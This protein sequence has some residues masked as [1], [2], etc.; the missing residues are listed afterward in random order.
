MRAQQNPLP[1]NPP[2]PPGMVPQAGQGQG[3]S[4]GI[5]SSVALVALHA[6]VV[7]DKG[8]FVPNLKQENFR[9]FED[10]VEQKISVFSRD[11]IP[12]TMGLVVDNSGSMREKRAQV[13]AAAMTFVKTSNPQDEAFVVNFNDEYYLDTEGDFT[14]D[15]HDLNDALSRIDTRGSTALYDAL[16]GSLDHLKKGHKDKRVILLIT[17]GEDDASR[18]TFEQTIK[19]AEQSNAAIYAVGV[20]SDDDRKN[21]KREVKH[22]KRVLS[23][24]ADATG[25]LAFFPDNLEQVEPI[26]VQIARDIRNQYLLGYYPTDTAQDGTFRA[27]SAQVIPPKGMG[28]LSIRTRAGYY[29]PK[30]SPEK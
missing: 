20:F 4:H 23:E 12:V 19:V 9:V 1:P 6:T 14:S 7:D 27:V 10:K 25:G 21:D 16:V 15:Q 17:D 26:C 24:L 18:L 30:P 11:D 28:K 8:Q 22:A 13:N 29:A 5:K 3:G 2:P